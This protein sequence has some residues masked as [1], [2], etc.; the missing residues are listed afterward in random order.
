MEE[1]PIGLRLAEIQI[2]LMRLDH[3]VSWNLRIVALQIAVKAPR[4][5]LHANASVQGCGPAE[6]LNQPGEDVCGLIVVAG[7]NQISQGC[8]WND[9]FKENRSANVFESTNSTGTLEG[10]Q[11]STCMPFVALALRNLQYDVLIAAAAEDKEGRFAF[12]DFFNVDIPLVNQQFRARMEVVFRRGHSYRR[13]SMGSR[14]AA[15]FAGQTPKMSPTPI[16]TT[17]P[18]MI[19]QGGIVAGS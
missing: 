2:R 1:S 4:P 19:A 6:A 13:H 5:I 9:S 10:L 12:A 18:A 17:S 11:N 3:Q 14:F 7:G 8:S 15:F 16:D